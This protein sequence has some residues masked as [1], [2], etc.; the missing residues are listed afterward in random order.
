[1]PP[2]G[3]LELPL[4]D[5][6]GDGP[7]QRPPFEDLGVGDLVGADDP[8]ALVGQTPGVG[9]APQHLLRPLLEAAVAPGGLPVTRAVRL[10]IDVVEEV[11]NGTRADGRDDALSNRLAGQI[12]AAP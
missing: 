12:L 2:P 1:M 11:P 9:V 8:E 5:E 7:A 10:Q 6:A 3:V 4:L